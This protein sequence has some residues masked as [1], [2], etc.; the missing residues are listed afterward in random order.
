MEVI[1]LS[2][3]IV[4]KYPWPALEKIVNASL[5]QTKSCGGEVILCVASELCLPPEGIESVENFHKNISVLILPDAGGLTLY[6]AGIGS[7]RSE[8]I[9]TLEDHNMIQPDWC[10]RHIELYR[11]NADIQAVACAVVNGTAITLVDKANFLLGFSTYH[12]LAEP[13][14][15]CR[16]PVVAGSSIRRTFIKEF[17]PE[18]GYV[19]T[20]AYW[21]AFCIGASYFDRNNVIVHYQHRNFLPM[22][23]NHFHNGKSN[24]G[25]CRRSYTWQQWFLRLLSSILSPVLSCYRWLSGDNRKNLA[26]NNE[27]NAVPLIILV[28]IVTAVGN[29][30]GLFFGVG[31]SGS[32]TE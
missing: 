24:A 15:N 4:S 7:A 14:V 32:R 9:A 10:K 5:I 20:V 27:M 17:P 8:I 28:Q 26:I 3:V 11:N 23:W 22:L 19:E 25:F 29:I 30:C 2:V 6:A 16:I 21:E 12:P 31:N 13:S 18:P 1:S